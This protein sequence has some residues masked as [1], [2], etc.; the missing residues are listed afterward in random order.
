M[1]G[2]FLSKFV[3]EDIGYSQFGNCFANRIIKLTEISLGLLTLIYSLLPP[4]IFLPFRCSECC[5]V[6]L[7]ER[8][9]LQAM[10]LHLLPF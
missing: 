3:E 1:E 7:N 9:A 8:A 5:L 6:V 10:L 2:F 4:A